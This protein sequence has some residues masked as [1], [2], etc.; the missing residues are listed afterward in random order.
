MR[1]ASLP[2][3]VLLTLTKWLKLSVL[4]LLVLV[5]LMGSKIEVHFGIETLKERVQTKAVTVAFQ[6]VK[7]AIGLGV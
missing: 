5:F 2:E 4:T 3:I 7:K 1:R 6:L